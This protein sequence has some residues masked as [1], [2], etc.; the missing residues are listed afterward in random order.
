MPPVEQLGRQV[1]L[2]DQA[3]QQLDVEAY[4]KARESA[5]LQGQVYNPEVGFALVGNTGGGQKYPY[6]P[7]YGA[8]SPRIAAAWNPSYSD[9]LLGRTI[10]PGQ[11]RRP[12]RLQQNLRPLERRR[13]RAGS[14]ARHRPHPTGSVH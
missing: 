14:S 12:R 6:N 2:V 4:L 1:E 3:G 5:A 13:S 8:F 7:F 9:G 10:R 11:N